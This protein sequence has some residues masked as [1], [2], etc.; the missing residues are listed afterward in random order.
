[1]E[2]RQVNKQEFLHE[3]K[4]RVMNNKISEGEV[5]QSLERKELIT[6]R[7]TADLDKLTKPEWEKAFADLEN[8]PIYQKEVELRESADE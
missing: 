8:D 3:L 5:F 4:Y 7:E 1:M 6:E 2:L